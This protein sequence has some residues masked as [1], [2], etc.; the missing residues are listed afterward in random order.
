[1]PVDELKFAI[2]R[3]VWPMSF[4]DRDPAKNITTI[5]HALSLD[6]ERPTFRPVLWNEVVPDPAQPGSQLRVTLGR[7]QIQQVWFAGVHANVGGG[8][9]DD[10]LAF[11]T[12]K[13]MMDEAGMGPFRLRYDPQARDEINARVNPHGEQYDSRAGVA[14]YYRY[15]PRNVAL[16]CNDKQH[17]VEVPVCWVHI[18]AFDRIAR[19]QR[20]YAPASLN[21]RFQLIGGNPVQYPPA[22]YMTPELDLLELAWDIVWWRRLAYFATLVTTIFVGLFF[23]ALV[24]EWP[25]DILASVENALTDARWAAHRSGAHSGHSEVGIGRSEYFA[26]M[27]RGGFTGDFEIS[28]NGHRVTYAAGNLV[29]RGVSYSPATHCSLCRVGLGRPEGFASG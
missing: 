4:A 20:A 14:G 16:L 15:G 25:K 11:T 29:F 5:R 2:D 8:Y 24:Y 13:W 7:D 1:M 10:G 19:Q 18:D 6:D 22:P 23:A 21:E 28:V 26:G 27:V 12:L 17:K 9:P 3:W